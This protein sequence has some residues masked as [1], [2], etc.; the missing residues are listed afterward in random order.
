MSNEPEHQPVGDEAERAR[1]HQVRGC[2]HGMKLCIS[3]LESDLPPS[4][5][6][7]FLDHLEQVASKLDRLL[8]ESGTPMESEV[9]TH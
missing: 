7:E 1:R 9:P 5:Q 2:V 4:E 6:V 3:A 8:D